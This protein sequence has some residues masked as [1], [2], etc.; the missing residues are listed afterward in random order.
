VIVISDCRRDYCH[1]RCGLITSGDCVRD[2]LYGA[3]LS[4]LSNITD[5]GGD[6]SVMYVRHGAYQMP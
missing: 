3:K 5:C 2:L 4:V 1:G 6:V